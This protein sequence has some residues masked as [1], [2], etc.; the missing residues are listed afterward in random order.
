MLHLQIQNPVPCL[1]PAVLDYTSSPSCGKLAKEARFAVRVDYMKGV[2][3]YGM[4]RLRVFKRKIPG[5]GR[6]GV[7]GMRDDANLNL[8]TGFLAQ[9]KRT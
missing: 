3:V 4:V 2:I 1:P 7:S 6:L 5:T 8:Q 9:L